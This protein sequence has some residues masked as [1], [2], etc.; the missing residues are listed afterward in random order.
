MTLCKFVFSEYL[1][2]ISANTKIANPAEKTTYL[3]K[4]KYLL[5]LLDDNK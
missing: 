1:T 4:L 3:W 5:S 2:N